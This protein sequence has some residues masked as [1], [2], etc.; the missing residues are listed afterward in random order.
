MVKASP[1][2]QKAE[3]LSFICFKYMTFLLTENKKTVLENHCGPARADDPPQVG[4]SRSSSYVS[5][6]TA[7]VPLLV[8]GSRALTERRR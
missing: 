4:L 8:I 5:V 2:I 6:L 1:I 7:L 3:E